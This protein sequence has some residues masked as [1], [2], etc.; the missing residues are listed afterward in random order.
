MET[1]TVDNAS[2]IPQHTPA[3]SNTKG[4]TLA[5]HSPLTSRNSLL[6][7]VD[8]TA[9][10]S[11]SE[12]VVSRQKLYDCIACVPQPQ[13]RICFCIELPPYPLSY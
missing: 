12:I 2:T 3:Y 13:S 5:Q 10:C 4:Q 9:G 8:P 6:R 1:F 11:A 7:P